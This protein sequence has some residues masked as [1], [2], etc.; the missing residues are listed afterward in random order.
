MISGT[1]L[2]L[3]L[4][5]NLAIFIVMVAVYG[6]LIS[7]F[8]NTHRFTRQTILGIFFGLFAV[9]CMYVKIPVAEGVIVDQRNT[10]VTLS[11]LFGGP[12]A[13]LLSAIITAAYRIS[14]G[15]A[16]TLAGAVG[17]CL[18]AIAG[19]CLRRYLGPKESICRGLLGA[20]AATVF[21]LP[22]FLLYGDLQT[23]WALL[24]S[25]AL[26]YGA[27]IFVGMF[28]VGLLLVREERRINAE[29]AQKVAADKLRDF[30]ESASDWFWELDQDLRF[31]HVSERFEEVIGN[32]TSEILG[33]TRW[34]IADT[35]LR[36][37][38]WAPHRAD[39]EARRPF[40]N[41]EYPLKL[42]DGQVVYCNVSGT[43]VFDSHGN[44]TGYRGSTSDITK[45]KQMEEKLLR[46]DRTKSEF[47][48]IASHELRTPLTSVLGYSELMLSNDNFSE[49]Q[50]REYLSEIYDRALALDRIIDELLD[51]S[52]IESGRMV[53]LDCTPIN[54]CELVNQVLQQ[55]RKEAHHHHF[56][57]LFPDEAPKVVA[58]KGKLE[59]IFENLIG[60]AI[61]F[62]PQGSEITVSGDVVDGHYQVTVADK[63]IGL[64]PEQQHVVFEKFYR[65]DNSDTATPGLGIGLHLVKNIVEA[66]R[67][68]VWIESTPGE[69]S[70][71]TFILPL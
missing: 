47:I 4:F 12:L 17:V 58:D 29:I 23:G 10:I 53:H 24:Q 61:K 16:G 55:F 21:I 7:H 2:F 32:H 52:R 64:S 56:I 19:L 9:A 35:R 69:G 15:G 45:R 13:A 63:G 43:P 1:S 39:L 48:A 42:R 57:S 71:V 66:H 36:P 37:E 41:F 33:K 5:N 50:R 11:G 65:V 28:L 46:N 20:L 44:F 70:Q 51:I 25:V 31:S 49:Q 59:Q 40:K 18:S 26:P 14:L 34:E 54:L 30:A 27:A 22:G 6:A 8:Q 68:R 67:G 38:I 62:S 3:G 60:N